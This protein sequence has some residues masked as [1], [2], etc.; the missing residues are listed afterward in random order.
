M[1]KRLEEIAEYYLCRYGQQIRYDM[2]RGT[3]PRRIEE[4]IILRK[5]LAKRIVKEIINEYVR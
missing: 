2:K 5:Q 3:T 4:Q 1:E